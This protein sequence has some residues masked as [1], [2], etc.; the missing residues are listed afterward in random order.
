[1]IGNICSS[2]HRWT[3]L[4]I[5]VVGCL[6]AVSGA[7]SKALAVLAARRLRWINLTQYAAVVFFTVKLYSQIL[8]KLGHHTI[9]LKLVET[10]GWWMEWRPKV[11]QLTSY[12]RLALIGQFIRRNSYRDSCPCW[13]TSARAIILTWKKTLMDLVIQGKDWLCKQKQLMV[14]FCPHR[15]W[16]KHVIFRAGRSLLIFFFFRCDCAFSCQMLSTDNQV[17]GSLQTQL[18]ALLGNQFE[19]LGK[20]LTRL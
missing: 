11:S 13:Q 12:Q 3:L 2:E 16:C 1:M 17:F 9:L 15:W 8:A 20:D 19:E 6:I 14:F 5:D 4:S 10:I 7:D 18:F